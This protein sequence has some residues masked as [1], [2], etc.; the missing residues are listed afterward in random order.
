MSLR[1]VIMPA[2]AAACG[3]LGG[4]AATWLQSVEAQDSAAVVRASRIELIDTSGNTK[5]ILGMNPVAKTTTLSFFADDGKALASFGLRSELPFIQL[6]GGDEKPR[7]TLALDTVHKPHLVFGD[8]VVEGRVVL[9][10]L[11]GDVLPDDPTINEWVLQFR[12]RSD[13]SVVIDIGMGRRSP[14]DSFLGGL[15]INHRQGTFRVPQ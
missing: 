10:A 5:A 6:F 1:R 12:D 11:G 2:L 9:G 13:H 14:A 3:F 7:A 8:G 15:M 4:W